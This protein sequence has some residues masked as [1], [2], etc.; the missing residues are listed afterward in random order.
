MCNGM[1]NNLKIRIL[2]VFFG[3]S[4][5]CTHTIVHVYAEDYQPYDRMHDLII[6]DGET[7]E[8]SG[9]T[10]LQYQKIP[11]ES[12]TVSNLS[13]DISTNLDYA[14]WWYSGWE[15]CRYIFLPVTADREQLIIS[16]SADDT[17]KLNGVPVKSGEMTSL[18]S[19]ADTFQITV[20]DVECGML[21]NMQSNLGCIYLSTSHCGLDALDNDRSIT[22]T[23]KVLML[24]AKVGTE[25]S[26]NIEKLTAHGN[27]SWDYSKKKPYNLKLPQKAN[28]YG[29]G[30]AKKWALLANYI[31][32]YK[33]VFKGTL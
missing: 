13:P 1:N 33:E 23:G 27:S 21:K 31:S 12:F 6:L 14:D 4:I 28:L 24:N 17:V 22:E 16:Y 7:Q 11:V 2:G 26:G 9:D 30:K 32:R 8:L 25:Y 29:M 18:L 10:T 5:I 20:E 15:D 3:L 19:D